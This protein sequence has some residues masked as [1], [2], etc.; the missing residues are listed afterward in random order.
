MFPAAS[1]SLTSMANF[2]R[3]L[4]CGLVIC[5]LTAA[6]ASSILAQVNP[7]ILISAPNSTRALT[8]EALVFTPEPFSTTGSSLLYG[9]DKRTR[10]MLFVRNLS[11]QA[12]DDLSF[13]TADAEDSAHRHYPLTVESLD[14]VPGQGWMKQLVLKLND[15]LAN[16]GDVLVS[17]TY[18]GVASNRVRV[19][20]GH[21][22]GGPLDD[23]PLTV[24]EYDGT[25]QNVD[26]G[27]FW[28][29]NVDLPKFFWEFWAMPGENA[30]GRY[31]LSDGYGGAHA[32]LFGFTSR[33]DLNRYALYGN[34]YDGA[35]SIDFSSDDG[36]TAGEW[37]HFAVGWDGHYLITYYNGVPVGRTPF[38]GPRRTPGPAG[39]GGHLFIGGS[40]HNNFIGRI[41]QVRGYEGLDPLEDTGGN[42]KTTSAFVPDIFFGLNGFTGKKA[43]FL[44]N[45]FHAERTTLDTAGNRVG[46]L[47]GGIDI[48]FPSPPPPLSKF[49]VDPTV[50]SAP[51][52]GGPAQRVERPADVP[53]GAKIFDSFSRRTSTL[54]F[55]GTGGLG[56]TEAGSDGPQVWQYGALNEKLYGPSIFGILNGRAVTLSGGPGIAWVPIKSSTGNL[57][58]RV[59]RHPGRAGSGV[60]SGICFRVKDGSNFFFA[61]TGESQTDPFTSRTLTIGVYINGGRIDLARGLTLP[62]NWTTLRVITLN[63]GTLGVYADDTPMW[64]A[65][66]ITFLKDEKGVGLYNDTNGLALTNRWDNFTVLDAP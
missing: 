13:I 41:A 51:T 45:F 7:P 37:G 21:T 30:F 46:T 17:I 58:V 63:D 16:V 53:A 20:M 57:E 19:G 27:P 23:A 8:L 52:F 6:S 42:R 18:R 38:A 35:N 11:L 4:L 50:P 65:A 40:D 47:R 60:Q 25:T 48:F 59:D 66:D 34:I 5:V 61:Y 10:I 26:F 1:I 9:P 22:G 15:D 56:L 2:Y 36:P 62:D 39:G 3:R 43:S 33:V 44:I 54:A 14:K 24:L 28:A 29:E 64:G 49:V 55:N 32:L 12:G 31:L